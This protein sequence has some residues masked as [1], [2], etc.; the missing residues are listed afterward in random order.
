MPHAPVT[1]W[2]YEGSLKIE[3]QAVTLSKYS[4]EAQDDHK[5][6][7]QV[8]NPRL[9]ST[10]FRSPQLTLIDMNPDEWLLYWKSPDHAPPHRRRHVPGMVQLLLFELFPQELAVCADE[11]RSGAHPQTHLHLVGDPDAEE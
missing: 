1:V 3:H 4:I 10:P 6:L 7:K 11:T 8:S 2:I 9:S 5:H